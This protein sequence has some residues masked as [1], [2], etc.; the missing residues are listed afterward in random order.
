MPLYKELETLKP[1]TILRKLKIPILFIHGTRDIVIP[2][3]DSIKYSKIT[4][5]G[6]LILIKGAGHGFDKEQHLKLVASHISKFL[7]KNMR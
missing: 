2:S 3:T 4:K 1:W 5:N 7:K 6:K